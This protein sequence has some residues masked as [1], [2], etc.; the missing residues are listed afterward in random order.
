MQSIQNLIASNHILEALNSLPEST[1][2]LLLKSR[3]NRNEKDNNL[4][5]LNYQNYLIERS[6]I[7]NAIL[8]ISG[9]SKETATQLMS[10]NNAAPSKLTPSE[11]RAIITR[12]NIGEQ[13][14]QQ[15]IAACSQV[16]ELFKGNLSEDE[17]L[18]LCGNAEMA[19]RKFNA[20]PKDEDR[21]FTLLEEVEKMLPDFENFSQVS[22]TETILET[23][24]NRAKEALTLATFK[25]Y[26]EAVLRKFPALG[27][28]KHEFEV[29]EIEYFDR[30]SNAT[31]LL[32]RMFEASLCEKWVN[33]IGK[34]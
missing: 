21:K 10:T 9:V 30:V 14:T 34:R 32:R 23:L 31:L 24:Y 1:T 33:K 12:K 7:V 29:D 17:Y 15:L 19:F 27:N 20:R 18:E 22:N 3:Y 26:F 25:P 4:G 28:L 5:L 6:R 13:E 8:D 16:L 2:V 11:I